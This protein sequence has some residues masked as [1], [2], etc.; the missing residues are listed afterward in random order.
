MAAFPC[1]QTTAVQ[2]RAGKIMAHYG[3]LLALRKQF[4]LS[5]AVHGNLAEPRKGRQRPSWSECRKPLGLYCEALEWAHHALVWP[6]GVLMR[7]TTAA[8]ERRP[9]R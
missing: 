8:R 1:D 6:R 2:E 4:D 7:L 5:Y 3:E 9:R